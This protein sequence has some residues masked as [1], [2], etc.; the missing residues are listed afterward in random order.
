MMLHVLIADSGFRLHPAVGC[1]GPV[2]HERVILNHPAAHAHGIDCID[3]T[4]KMAVVDFCD[5][6]THPDNRKYSTPDAGDLV[7]A[8]PNRF[9]GSRYQA[10]LIARFFVP[11][12]H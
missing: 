5:D 12:V 6:G 3:D 9:E 4:I 8:V 10:S 2:C 1:D 11:T 7:D